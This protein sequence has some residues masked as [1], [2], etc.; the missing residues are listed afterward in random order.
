MN[1]IDDEENGKSVPMS[2]RLETIVEKCG[3]EDRKREK[4]GSDLRLSLSEALPL[5]CHN[6]TYT[7]F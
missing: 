7:F 6:Y 2:V 3:K 1:Q 5:P 4:E